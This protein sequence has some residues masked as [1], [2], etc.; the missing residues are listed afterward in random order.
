MAHTEVYSTRH[1][2]GL[3]QAVKDM[4]GNMAADTGHGLPPQAVEEKV[5]TLLEQGYPLSQEQSLAIRFATSRGGRVAV[6]EG[7][8]DSGK[9]TT[10][11]PIT[12][13]HR[14]TRL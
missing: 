8:A 5:R 1:N 13:L 10:L 14:E 6:I 4:A 2:L 9:T 12:D 3:E 7:A 11:R